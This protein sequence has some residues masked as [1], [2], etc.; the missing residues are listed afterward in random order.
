MGVIFGSRGNR[1]SP[2]EA[3]RITSNRRVGKRQQ[4]QRSA[5]PDLN[6]EPCPRARRAV[7]AD[8]ASVL[9][10]DGSAEVEPKPQAAGPLAGG[11]AHEAIEDPRL[12]VGGEARAD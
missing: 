10:D 8:G 7:D 11:A 6:P 4:P 3:I 9:L 5:N 2:S 12:L 1:Q